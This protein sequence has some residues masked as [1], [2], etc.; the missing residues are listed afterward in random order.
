MKKTNTETVILHQ[1]NPLGRFSDRAVDYAKYRPTYPTE[2]IDK[3]LE[4]L[5]DRSQ[6]VV[7]DIG[8]GTSISSRLLADR[9]IRVHAIEPNLEMRQAAA[10]HPQVEF[11]EGTAEK[12]NLADN[13]VEL[14]SCFQSFHWF[15]PEPTLLE[16]Y[17]ILKPKGKVALVWNLDDR[18]DKFTQNCEELIKRICDD[19]PDRKSFFSEK[20]LK[21]SSLFANFTEHN[22]SHRKEYDLEGL[23]GFLMSHSF[24]PRSGETYQRLISGLEELFDR[25]ADKNGKVYIAYRTNLYLAERKN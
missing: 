10:H 2:A 7:A 4:G 22:F 16:F 20:D 1:L 19:Y 17:R 12:T 24:V 11:R 21:N 5:G 15:D 9:G 25:F 18:D 3:I 23:I 13:S 14:V 6:L 8:A